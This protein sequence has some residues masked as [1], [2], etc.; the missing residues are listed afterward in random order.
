[1]PRTCTHT[2]P[3]ICHVNCQWSWELRN[4]YLFTTPASNSGSSLLWVPIRIVRLC[5][6]YPLHIWCALINIWCALICA[7]VVWV[8][9][10]HLRVIT[11]LMCID[12]SSSSN[13]CSS[14]LWVPIRIVRLCYGYPLHIWC[15]LICPVVVWVLYSH[16]RVTTH[17]MCIDMCSSCVDVVYAC[18]CRTRLFWVLCP[19]TCVIN[20]FDV[21]R[22]T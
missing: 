7:V 4:S 13:S 21:V 22:Y 16:V 19:F 18:S 10:T 20:W 17:L 6:G 8:L 14:L 11:H 2:Y 5:Y 9:Y 12:M 3:Q 1:M 15:A